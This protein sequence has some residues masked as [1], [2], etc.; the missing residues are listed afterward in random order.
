[1]PRR[2][3]TKRKAPSGQIKSS[4]SLVAGNESV[5]TKGFF[6]LP[7][8][9]RNK[10]YELALQNEVVKYPKPTHSNK[11]GRAAFPGLLMA[12]KRINKEV[13]EMFYSKVTFH[14]E[15]ADKMLSWLRKLGLKKRNLV[16]KVI[17]SDTIEMKFDYTFIAWALLQNSKWRRMAKDRVCENLRAIERRLR[18]HGLGLQPGSIT[19]RSICWMDSKRTRRVFFRCRHDVEH[20]GRLLLRSSRS[21]WKA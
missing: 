8:E 12:S 5:S 9:M 2:K 11:K 16:R 10:I 19:T 7:A 13:L 3:T 14:F 15:V 17:V 1:M 4:Q 21:D 18:D 20:G 6:D